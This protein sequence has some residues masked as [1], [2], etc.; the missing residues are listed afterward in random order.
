[1]KDRRSQ[2]DFAFT[3]RIADQLNNFDFAEWSYFLK[4]LRNHLIPKSAFKIS[5]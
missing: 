4:N 5:V 2:D 1:M 3:E